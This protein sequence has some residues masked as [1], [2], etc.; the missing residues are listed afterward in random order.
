MRLLF[1]SM[2]LVTDTI[3]YKDV[4]IDVL[5][6]DKIGDAQQ[7]NKFFKLKNNFAEAR[8]QN[9]DVMLTYGG[10]FSNHIYATAAAGKENNLKTIGI[11]RGEEDPNNPTL[12]FARS[13]GMQLEFISREQYRR[14][15]DKEYVQ[16]LQNKF[17]AFYL[18]PEGGTNA[19]AI[20]GCSEIMQGREAQYDRIFLPVGTGG[21]IAGIISTPGLRA[22]VTGILVL[23][24]DD[25]ITKNVKS[26]LGEAERSAMWDINLNFHYGGYAKYNNQLVDFIRSFYTNY[27][28]LLDPVYTGKMMAGIFYMIDNQKIQPGTKIC[29]IHTGGLQGIAGWNYRFEKLIPAL[30]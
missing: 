30:D 11:I 19:L 5:R 9:F 3:I 15:N 26:F 2:Q 23:R 28:M 22:H 24:G 6:L 1:L 12:Q 7:G 27:N 29:A 13:N 25:T 17:G 18:L 21:T 14:R 10:P 20:K 4:E 8:R 16:Y